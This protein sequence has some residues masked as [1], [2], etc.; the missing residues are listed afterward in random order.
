M[1]RKDQ[2]NSSRKS[3]ENPLNIEEEKFQRIEENLENELGL[4]SSGHNIHHAK[5]VFHLGMRIAE[6]EGGDKE[7]I[8]A[9]CLT[10]DIHRNMKEEGSKLVDPEKSLPRIREILK[11]SN[12]PEGK[13]EDVLHCVKVHEEYDFE[14]ETTEAE[15][16][17]AKIVQDADNLDATGAIGIGR[18]FMFSGAHNRPMWNP[19]IERENRPYNKNKIGESTIHHFYD[20]GIKLKDNMNTE[21]ARRIA[22]DRHR[23]MKEFVERFKKEWL[24]KI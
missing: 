21:T 5:R 24:G 14:E 20:K 1:N 18:V 12:F 13:I 16:L 22:E 9:A 7:V 23:Y 3:Y 8:G 2:D 4:D 6:E 11:E 19:R 17:E 10:H 15:T